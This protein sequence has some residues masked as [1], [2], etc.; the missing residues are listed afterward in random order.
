MEDHDCSGDWA[1]QQRE[2]GMIWRMKTQIED[3]EMRC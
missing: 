3:E 1:D 2:Q